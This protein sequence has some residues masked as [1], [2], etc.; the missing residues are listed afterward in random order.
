LAR[1]LALQHPVYGFLASDAVGARSPFDAVAEATD[2]TRL[3]RAHQ[4]AGPYLLIGLCIG[5]RVAY[6]MAQQLL[7][8]G[9]AIAGLFLVDTWRPGRFDELRTDAGRDHGGGLLG[10]LP[11]LR[12]YRAR[13]YPGRLTLL[14]NQEWHAQD[15]TLGWGDLAR[16][17]IDT[18]VIAGD[19]RMFHKDRIASVAAPLRHCLTA[20]IAAGRERR[21][22]E[23]GGVA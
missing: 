14:L 22:V 3:L 12:R 21:A 10:R 23:I 20:A 15:P 18:H 13:P 16:G 1:H 5:G 9:E 7:A 11:A 19:H 2:Y 4:P 8:E 17:G 6:E